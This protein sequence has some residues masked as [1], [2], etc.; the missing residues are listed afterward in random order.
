MNFSM[1]ILFSFRWIFFLKYCTCSYHQVKVTH[2][3]E[4]NLYM[5][6]VRATLIL[7]PLLGIEFVLIPWRPEGKIAEEIYDY[8][9]SILMHYQVWWSCTSWRHLVMFGC[10]FTCSF[11]FIFDYLFNQIDYQKMYLFY[12]ESK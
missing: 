4:S 3:A 1:L 7:V 12:L 2:Q 11:D 10:K 6:A 8:I 5:K 9:A